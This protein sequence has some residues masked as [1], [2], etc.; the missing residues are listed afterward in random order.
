M[1]KLDD[2]P[3][4]WA[5]SSD[6]LYRGYH[7][8]EW[9]V[10]ERDARA[11]WEKFQLDGHQAGLSWIT[12]LRKRE[13]MRE[14]FDGFQPEKIARWTAKRID[15]AMKNPGHHPLA[16]QDRSDDQERAGL[17]R[18]GREGRRLLRLCL[19]LRGQQAGGEPA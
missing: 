5:P 2:I 7:D 19:E 18:H 10:P 3:C 8:H 15:K 11:L 16:H 12:I 9:G 4:G 17:S 1:K 6:A 13:T 14:E